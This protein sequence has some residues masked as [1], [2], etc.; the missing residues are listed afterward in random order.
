[1]PENEFE[2]E[3]QQKMEGL[4]LTPDS[5]IWENVAAKISAQKSR[6]R[7]AILPVVLLCCLLAATMVVTDLRQTYFSVPR[8]VATANSPVKIASDDAGSNKIVSIEKNIHVVKTGRGDIN[9]IKKMPAG[10]DQ[11]FKVQQTLNESDIVSELSL[12]LSQK[13]HEPVKKTH[14]T[15]GN[16]LFQTQTQEIEETAGESSNN[17]ENATLKPLVEIDHDTL[18]T[19]TKNILPADSVSQATAIKK[20]T[21][22]LLSDTLIAVK[23]QNENRMA[24]WQ[25]GIIFTVGQA[26]TASGY[27]ASSAASS[28]ADY[29]NLS[30]PN[31]P[32]SNNQY[33]QIINSSYS[34][35]RIKPAAGF[36]VGISATRKLSA[37]TNFVAALT[38]KLFTTSKVIGGDSLANGRVFYA[39]GNTN[40]YRN[41]FH[42]IEIPFTLQ[43]QL[44]RIKSK[45][46][47]LEAGV[48]FS[49]LI[50]S[51][52]LQYDISRNK[53]YVD[54][55]LFNKTII[56]LS[57]ALSVNL[58]DKNK[59]ALLVGPQFY[60]SATPIA[61]SGLYAKTHYSFIGIKL[62]KMLKKN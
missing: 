46:L 61:T 31:Y 49:Q 51:N 13:Q 29:L 35:A 47:L 24:K 21:A 40:S 44:A 12:T 5:A 55:Q 8:D 26:S 32:A 43:T 18:A 10:K 20:M 56:G 53:Y 28:Y 14:Q 37:K 39:V 25:L 60:Y 9:A 19:G 27:L 11:Y 15:T 16:K 22:K 58:L 1:M 34:P 6:R 41:N 54:N 62:Q 48:T 33:G 57:A 50:S 4:K 3:V 59:P 23:K 42:F 45:S 36:T 30:S 38:Y 7:P 2:K 52:A 17:K